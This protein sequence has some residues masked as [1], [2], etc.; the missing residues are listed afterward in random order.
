M[1]TK[2][3]RIIP[4]GKDNIYDTHKCRLLRVYNLTEMDKLFLFR[5]EDPEIAKNWNFKPGQF[6][7]V[8]LPGIGEVPISICSSAMR[9]GFFE[10]CVR[11]AGRVT[12]KI[13]ELLP[14][15]LVGIRGPYGNG[16]P[17][18]KFWDKDLLLVAAGLGMAPLRSVFLYALD[19]RWRFGN[20]TIINSAKYCEELLFDKELEALRDIAEA[21]NIKIIQTV[22][23]ESECTGLKGRAHQ[24]LDKVNVNPGNCGVALCGPPRMYKS[25]FDEL[26]KLNFDPRNIFVTLER[27]MK[28]GVGKCGHCNLG[29][30]TSWKYACKDGPVFDYYDIISTP[31][32]LE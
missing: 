8:S 6:V 13:H 19:N 7:E 25:M 10:L 16:F 30:S 26:V 11:K 3:I 24:H 20:I 4:D 29:N 22:T 31:G 18:E 9:I 32:M 12:T 5:F 15:T 23:R 14:G 27:R 28:C 17:M 1:L 2:K 21:E